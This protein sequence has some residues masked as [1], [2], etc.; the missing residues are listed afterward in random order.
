MQKIIA[1]IVV[2]LAIGAGFYYFSN[3]ANGPAPAG[4]SMDSSETK[5]SENNTENSVVSDTSNTNTVMEPK[6]VIVAIGADGKF[7][8]DLVKI[9]KGEIVTWKNT[10][11]RFIWPASAI[12][13]THQIYPE[14]DA[15]KGIAPGEEYSFTFDK[16]GIWKY[17]DH[18]RAST[19]GTIEVTE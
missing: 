7:T 6:T 4:N 9:K 11:D 1:I 2:L 16:A 8:P 13:P 3:S 18:L 19:F 5:N 10:T 12:H 14:F 17:H 15:K